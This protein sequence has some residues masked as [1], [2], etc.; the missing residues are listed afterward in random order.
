MNSLSSVL[1]PVWETAFS[2]LFILFPLAFHCSKHLEVLCVCALKK[3]KKQ[4][5]AGPQ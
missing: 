4:L 3:K 5:V 2:F 1:F